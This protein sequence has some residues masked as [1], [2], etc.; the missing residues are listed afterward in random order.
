MTMFLLTILLA[1]A[2]QGASPD[3]LTLESFRAW[4]DAANVPG[5]NARLI[6]AQMQQQKASLPPW[7]PDEVW[8]EEEEA[9]QKVDFSVPALPFYQ[10]CFTDYEVH[11][12][13]KLTLSKT[14]QQLAHTATQTHAQAAEQGAVPLDAQIAGENAEHKRA[15]AV[16]DEEKQKLAL[17]FTPAERAFIGRDFSELKLAAIRQCTHAAYA[18]TA[19]VV[20][21]QQEEAMKTVVEAN[22]PRLEAARAQ[23]EKDHP[24]A[25]SR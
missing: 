17:A 16:S 14:G 4:L 5:E 18:K 24:D 10:A 9:M 13:T 6:H 3:I 21:G 7:W 11:L 12:I 22:R 20:K 1:A 8:A 19:E 23:W 2:P 25:T 15:A